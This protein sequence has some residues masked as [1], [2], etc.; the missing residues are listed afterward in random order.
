VTPEGGGSR[1]VVNAGVHPRT[2]LRKRVLAR[3]R[4]PSLRRAV[5]ESLASLREL[6][7]SI[8]MG[9]TT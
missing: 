1:V 6:V 4:R 8:E 9:E 2:F 7:R 5:H 3:V